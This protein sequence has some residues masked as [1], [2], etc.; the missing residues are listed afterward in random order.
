MRLLLLCL[1]LL[2][3]SVSNA[4][5][6]QAIEAAEYDPSQNRWLV[7]NQSS[8][9]AQDMNGDLSY[10]GSGSATHGMEVMNGTLFAISGS[11]IKGYD[12]VSGDE[13]MSLFVTGASFL[14]GMG[15]DPV[16]NRLWVSDFG[17]GRIHELDVSDLSSPTIETI[18]SNT[19]STPNGVVYDSFND[20]V[21]FVNWGGNAAVK[22][23]DLSDNSVTTLTTTGLSNCDGIDMDNEGKFYISSWSPTRITRY[24]NDLSNPVIVT[25]SGL[26]NPADISYGL[27]INTLGIANSGSEI[28]TLIEFEASGIDAIDASPFNLQIFP[29]PISVASRVSFE[30]QN[31]REVSIV[32][33]NMEGKLV[34]RIL[35]GKQIQ[36]KH[37]VLLNGLQLAEGQYFLEVNIGSEIMIEPFVI[38]H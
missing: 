36:G 23:I 24:D 37:Q 7:S 3:V 29:N 2:A 13:V 21:L 14:N 10:F 11:T 12:L 38:S 27:E 25:S 5:S 35:S 18:V 9:I 31:D 30:I 8:I 28:L 17:A 33:R 1:S 19:V 16:S 20:R 26:S 22:E 4:Q 6:Y 34:D 15:S 32:V